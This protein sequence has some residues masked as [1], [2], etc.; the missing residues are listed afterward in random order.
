MKNLKKLSSRFLNLKKAGLLIML[1]CIFA[2]YAN[3]QTSVEDKTG[4]PYFV[5]LSDNPN[6]EQLPLK[7]TSATVNIVGVIADFHDQ[8]FH[9]SINPIFIAP[10]AR[11]YNELAV[12]INMN[13]TKTILTHIENQW[14]EYFPNFIFEYDFLDDRIAELYKSEQQFLSLTK[15]FSALALF[16]G[17]LGIYGL[18]LFYVTQKTKEIGIRKVLGGNVFHILVLV[19]QD[20]FKLVV[21]AKVGEV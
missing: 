16:I 20:F 12:K 21:I 18:I 10:L 13:N 15:V 1:S 6:E 2:F 3:A 11:S 17:C 8:D 14:A 9:N 19:M 4:S 5:V 7:E